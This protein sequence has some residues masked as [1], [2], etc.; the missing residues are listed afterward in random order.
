MGLRGAGAGLALT[1]MC[2]PVLLCPHSMT[3]WG[4]CPWGWDSGL[5]LLQHCQLGQGC[6]TPWVEVI[7][8]EGTG[9]SFFLSFHPFLSLSTHAGPQHP[10]TH[11]CTSAGATSPGATLLWCWW[12]LSS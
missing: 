1:C 12:H 5:D 3:G 11:G 4:L 2:P 6:S 9:P 10:Q 7:D 8:W